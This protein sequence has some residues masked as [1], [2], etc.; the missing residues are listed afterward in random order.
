M[1]STFAV[2]TTRPSWSCATGAG[3]IAAS[4]RKRG[5]AMA[6]V[7]RVASNFGTNRSAVL[8][9]NLTPT[10]SPGA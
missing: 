6:K 4:Q 3:C 1:L 8:I 2:S 7:K 9:E 5:G 10:G